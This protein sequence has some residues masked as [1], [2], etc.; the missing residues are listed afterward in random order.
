VFRLNTFLKLRI[1]Q[2]RAEAAAPEAAEPRHHFSP[3]D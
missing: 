1:A 2:L 3:Q